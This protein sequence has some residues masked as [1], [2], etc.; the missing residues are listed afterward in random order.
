[1]TH[2]ILIIDDSRVIRNI[3]KE[4]FKNQN[5]EI[6][7][8]A[9]GVRGLEAI[10]TEKPALV[11]LDFLLPKLSGWDVYK[12]ILNTPKYHHIPLVII[13]GR[14]EEVSEKVSEPFKYFAFVGKPFEKDALVKGCREAQ[15]K[16]QQRQQKIKTQSVKTEQDLNQRIAYL[17]KTVESLLMRIKIIEDVNRI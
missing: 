10:E 8:A 3:V 1:M 14:K 5:I 11:L 16:A 17:E 7:E 12:T 2:K 4:I 9:N 15:Q 6:I 13:S